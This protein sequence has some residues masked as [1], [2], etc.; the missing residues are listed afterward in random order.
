MNFIIL[1]ALLQDTAVGTH[2]TQLTTEGPETVSSISNPQE[3]I[4]LQH[5]GLTTSIP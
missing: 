4:K 3:G 2:N 1:L 5:W